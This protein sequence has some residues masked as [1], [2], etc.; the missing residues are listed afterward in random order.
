MCINKVIITSLRREQY[1]CQNRSN[2]QVRH[3][4]EKHIRSQN[5]LNHPINTK[6]VHPNTNLSRP[7]THSE[8]DVKKAFTI[9][10]NYRIL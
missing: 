7:L 8:E 2:Q 3:R 1:N 10:I 5:M 6:I 9:Y 4:T